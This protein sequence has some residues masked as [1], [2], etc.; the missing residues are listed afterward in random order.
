MTQK[1]ITHSFRFLSLSLSFPHNFVPNVQTHAR[2]QLSQNAELNVGTTP[3]VTHSQRN[4]TKKQNKTND[5]LKGPM[6]FLNK[7]PKIASYTQKK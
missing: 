5:F 1:T 7:Q 3:K 6:D 2:R 4:P